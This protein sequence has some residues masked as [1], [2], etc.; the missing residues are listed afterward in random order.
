VDR[1]IG[2]EAL[3][4]GTQLGEAGRFLGGMNDDEEWFGV[5]DLLNEVLFVGRS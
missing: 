2:L 1:E 5:S 4:S 3:Q